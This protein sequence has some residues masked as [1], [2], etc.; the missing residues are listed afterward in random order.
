VQLKI[1]SPEVK[2]ALPS[3]G[4]EKDATRVLLRPCGSA[5]LAPAVAVRLLTA[6]LDRMRSKPARGEQLAKWMRQVMLHHAGR[7]VSIPLLT[8]VPFPSF[9][10]Q[11]LNSSLPLFSA[12][13]A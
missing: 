6:A 8:P 5:R 2:P 12:A 10:L 1:S 9:Q 7:E 13:A 3:S 4:S 11:L